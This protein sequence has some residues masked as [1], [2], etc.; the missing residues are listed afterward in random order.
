MITNRPIK[1]CHVSSAHGNDDLRILKKECVSLAEV[2]YD[3]YYVTR[4]EDS[5][6]RGVKIIGAGYPKKG[7]IARAFFFAKR[8]FKVAKATNCDIYHL[9]DP[10]LLRFAIKLKR[11][12]KIVIFDSHECYG[13]QI[14]EKQYI[15][16]LFRNILK[17]IYLIWE[18]KICK[19]I[20]AVITVC[21]IDGKSFFDGRAKLECHI[22]NYPSIMDIDPKDLHRYSTISKSDFKAIYVGAL[23]DSRGITQLVQACHFAGVHLILCGRFSNPEY[24]LKVE[25]M[26]EY[27]CVE[28]LGEIPHE[29]IAHEIEKADVGMLTLLDQGQ[30]FHADTYATKVL[31]YMEKGIPVIV[32]K[33]IFYQTQNEK[34]NFGICVDTQDYKNISEAIKKLINNPKLAQALGRNGFFLVRD[35]LNWTKCRHALFDL[36]ATLVKEIL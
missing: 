34:H 3:V 21:K 6:Y 23:T 35:E 31:E 33:T 17:K 16:K 29:L 22:P 14:S 1:V 11:S 32:P 36:Y 15:P 9:H 10:E 30:Y 13:L 18:T 7:L 28:Y 2:G 19:K 24:E 27:S 26:P 5:D 20:D 12:G 8:V 25:G 4:G